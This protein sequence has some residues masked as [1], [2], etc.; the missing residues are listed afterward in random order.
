MSIESV[1]PSD[2]LILRRP[3]LLSPSIFPIRVFS[4]ESVCPIRWSK[5][6]SFSFSISPSNDYLGFPGGS[7]RRESTCSAGDQSSIPG[8]GRS[9]SMATHSRSRGYPLWE[10]G[11]PLQY[12]CLEIPQTEEP[13]GPQSQRVG[14]D[15]AADRS[16]KDAEARVHPRGGSLAP[17]GERDG[18]DVLLNLHAEYFCVHPS[19]FRSFFPPHLLSFSSWNMSLHFSG[20]ETL[21]SLYKL[22]ASLVLWHPSFLA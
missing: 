10:N 21:V 20:P 1:M 4:N 2:H 12:S 5:Y 16:A 18:H 22:S 17:P 9:P 19:S 8:L 15:W 11:Y 6:W 13:G 7:D 14:H 3:L